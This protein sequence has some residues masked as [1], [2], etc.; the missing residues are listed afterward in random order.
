[1]HIMKAVYR[2]M[3]RAATAI[4][5]SPELA[6]VA[7]AAVAPLLATPLSR[8]EYSLRL[9]E[10]VRMRV[11]SELSSR[12]KKAARGVVDGRSFQII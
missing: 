6:P 1:M 4:D 10:V 7:R 8:K 9:A 11:R 5:N 3:M 12:S 2:A